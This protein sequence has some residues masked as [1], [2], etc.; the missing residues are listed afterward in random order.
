MTI[1]NGYPIMHNWDIEVYSWFIFELFILDLQFLL[2]DSSDITADFCD[3]WNV[4]V[5]GNVIKN[6]CLIASDVPWCPNVEGWLFLIDML[7]SVT[8]MIW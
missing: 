3:S 2:D 5:L 8:P 1:A 7:T 6:S 4:I